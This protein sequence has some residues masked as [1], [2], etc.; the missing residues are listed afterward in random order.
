MDVSLRSVLTAGAGMLTATAV[1]MA[2]AV[3]PPTL[4]PSHRHTRGSSR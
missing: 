2:P 3:I 4:T 1:V